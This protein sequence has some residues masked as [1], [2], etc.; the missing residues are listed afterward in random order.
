MRKQIIG[1]NKAIA[2]YS[3]D[4]VCAYYITVTSHPTVGTSIV[5]ALGSIVVAAMWACL[6]SI[7]F[8]DFNH[9]DTYFFALVL[10]VLFLGVVGPLANLLA[11]VT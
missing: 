10:E 3:Q 7:C 9:F 8:I 11:G 6:G 2:I 4:V 1:Y 5:T